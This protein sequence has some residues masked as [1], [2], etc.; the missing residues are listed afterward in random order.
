MQDAHLGERD[1]ALGGELADRLQEA[2]AELGQVLGLPVVVLALGLGGVE[3]GLDLGVRLLAQDVE[4][5]L[6]E[7]ADRRHRLLGA[8]EVAAVADDHRADPL[9]VPLGRDERRSGR[10]DDVQPHRQ[11]ARCRTGERAVRVED[12]R[13]TLEREGDQAAEHGRADVVQAEGE[14]GDDTEAGARAA[15]RPEQVGVLVAAG[16]ADLAVGGDDLG[17]EQ[18]VDGPAEPAGEVA[19]P[20]AERQPGDADLGE[21][22]ERHG[23]A[24]CLGRAVDVAEQAARLHRRGA[25][26]PGRR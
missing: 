1:R 26:R 13:G 4:D 17:L 20:A 9:A 25:R 8:R 3:V 21:E 12:L 24:V 19:E 18:V 14:L 7:R 2:V 5:R 15:E 11:L 6:A 22:A 23:E 16:P 10:A